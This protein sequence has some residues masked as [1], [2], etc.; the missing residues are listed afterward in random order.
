MKEESYMDYRLFLTHVQSMCSVLDMARLKDIVAG[1]GTYTAKTHDELVKAHDE[2]ARLQGAAQ[3]LRDLEEM[4]RAKDESFRIGISLLLGIPQKV[5]LKGDAYAA[6]NRDY[7][8]FAEAGII[9]DAEELA[10]SNFPLWKVIREILRQTSE[11]R[12]YELEEHL[13]SFEVKASRSAIE[14][15]LLTHKKQFRIIKRGREKFVAL[16]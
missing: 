6:T 8:D 16:K 5:N 2:R 15:A 14:S 12:V 10:V 13:R 4:V 3:R 9:P 7:E 11:I 1:L